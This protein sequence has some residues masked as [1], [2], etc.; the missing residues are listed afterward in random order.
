MKPHFILYV[1]DQQNSTK[2]Y[3][4]VLGFSPSLNVPGMTEFHL[5]PHCVLG[6]MPEAGIKRLLADKIRDPAL[7]SGIPRAELY[8]LVE[9][10]SELHLRALH[11][12]AQELSPLNV[13]DWG[14]R[15][16]YVLD[17]DGHVVAF[18]E[19]LANK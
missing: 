10:P 11:A 18:A 17:P 4:E 15:A 7:G 3:A 13:R 12:G 5:G 2:F 14:H 1:R 19:P 6:I 8:L 9:N 16:S